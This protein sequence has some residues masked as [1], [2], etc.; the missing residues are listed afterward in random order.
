[1]KM[2]SDEFSIVSGYMMNYNRLK[3]VVPNE[4]RVVEESL[5][6]V[7]MYLKLQEHEIK[8]YELILYVQ[9]N[10]NWYRIDELDEEDLKF[11][12]DKVERPFNDLRKAFLDK[13][14]LN[15]WL[16]Y[17]GTYDELYVTFNDEQV[18][19]LT[20]RAKALQKMTSGFY[21]DEWI[22]EG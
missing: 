19:E 11:V 3:D 14:E 18:V 7:M 1:M 22:E 13:T 16:Y 5:D 2:M 10:N 20:P 21:Y 17:S 12:K 9:D 15:I 8:R 6:D 4:V